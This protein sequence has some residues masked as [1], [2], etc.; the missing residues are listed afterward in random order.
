MKSKTD[1]NQS[2]LSLEFSSD[3]KTLQVAFNRRLYPNASDASDKDIISSEIKFDAG[4]IKGHFD[5]AIWSSELYALKLLLEEIKENTGKSMERSFDF[6]EE[7]IKLSFALS[8]TGKVETAITLIANHAENITATF[9]LLLELNDLLAVITSLDTVL[10]K[11]PVQ[12][13]DSNN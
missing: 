6:T 12:S 10:E 7:E 3:G 1:L 5:A 11:F 9:T 2:G 4:S 13:R 8:L